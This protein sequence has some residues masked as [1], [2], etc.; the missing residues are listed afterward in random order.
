MNDLRQ[1]H[2]AV[3]T[4]C[5]GRTRKTEAKVVRHRTQLGWSIIPRSC[6]TI[7][8]QCA[9]E[10]PSRIHPSPPYPT[11]Q[12]HGIGAL[13]GAQHSILEEGLSKFGIS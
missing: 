10:N 6:L 13:G 8:P 7:A 1:V 9:H 4:R 12:T 11:Q 3:N 2:I 5:V